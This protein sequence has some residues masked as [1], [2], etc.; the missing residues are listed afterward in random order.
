MNPEFLHWKA[1]V[2][3]WTAREILRIFK[4]NKERFSAFC[5]ESYPFK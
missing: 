2:N 3:H 1:S 4:K 5:F